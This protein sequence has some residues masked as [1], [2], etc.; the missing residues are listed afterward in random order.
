MTDSI[1][2]LN[3]IESRLK[4]SLIQLKKLI[5]K[6][7]GNENLYENA[8]ELIFWPQD[9]STNS[10]TK[11]SETQDIA[12]IQLHFIRDLFTLYNNHREE[13]EKIFEDLCRVIAE[14]KI[15]QLVIFSPFLFN[16]SKLQFLRSPSTTIA[17]NASRTLPLAFCCV[18]SL[19]L[20]D[21]VGLVASLL[22]MMDVNSTHAM[23]VFRG[24]F[25]KAQPV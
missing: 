21:P 7:S 14:S 13:S 12:L 1:T 16:I 3:T 22:G 2:D 11:S 20:H 4:N 25:L 10:L 8:I 15:P 19:I 6:D 17:Y 18:P 23:Y 5:G 9:D 24:S